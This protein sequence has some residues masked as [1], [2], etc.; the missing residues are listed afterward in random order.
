MFGAYPCNHFILHFDHRFYSPPR[1]PPSPSNRERPRISLK[2]RHLRLSV[3]FDGVS[4]RPSRTSRDRARLLVMT[5]SATDA[6]VLPYI[7][8]ITP[9]GPLRARPG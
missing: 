1:F 3:A 7:L 8:R 6:S 9:E 5:R 4:R 2:E